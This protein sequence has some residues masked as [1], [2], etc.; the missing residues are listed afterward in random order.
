MSFS[1]A[2][3]KYSLLKVGDL[4]LLSFSLCRKRTETA[5]ADNKK[6]SY[7]ISKSTLTWAAAYRCFIE[8]FFLKIA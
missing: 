1:E 7:E 8:Y 4:S 3:N 6:K 2:S 5:G